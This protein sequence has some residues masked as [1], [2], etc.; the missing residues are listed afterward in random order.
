MTAPCGTCHGDG[1]V[2]T[3]P[4]GW[5]HGSGVFA[6]EHRCSDCG[7]SG[8]A[9]EEEPG[10]ELREALAT[11]TFVVRRMLGMTAPLI[12]TRQERDALELLM[13]Y[14]STPDA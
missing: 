14:A 1:V 13:A 11:A 5:W 10:H 4:P 8:D 2:V 3:E 12:P 6:E 9:L 7:G